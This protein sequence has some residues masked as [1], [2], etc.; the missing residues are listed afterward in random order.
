[1]NTIIDYIT[2]QDL[3]VSK[4]DI[5]VMEYIG[6]GWQPYFG[7][8]MRATLPPGQALQGMEFFQTMVKYSE[9]T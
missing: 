7:Q 9:N 2:L 6:E 8:S 4:L 5:K 1:M 3:S